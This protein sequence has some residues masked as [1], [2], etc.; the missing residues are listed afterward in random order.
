MSRQHALWTSGIAPAHLE[1]TFSLDRDG[2]QLS[3]ALLDLGGSEAN[4]AGNEC[5]P[6]HLGKV[7]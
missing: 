6:L 4:E 3:T 7:V 2:W 5:K 1:L